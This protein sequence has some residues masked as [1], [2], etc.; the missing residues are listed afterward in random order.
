MVVESTHRGEHSR[1]AWP[2]IRWTLCVLCGLFSIPTS[3]AR[4]V[5]ATITGVTAG[6][7][8]YVTYSSNADGITAQLGRW[9]TPGDA[10]D[11]SKEPD[12]NSTLSIAI[13]VNDGGLVSFTY[14]ARSYDS[15][16]FD[17]LDVVLQT[18]TGDVPIIQNYGSQCNCGTLWW[19]DRKTKHQS[20]NKWKNQQVNFLIRVHQDGFGDQ[21]QA[22]IFNFGIRACPVPPLT[23]LTDPDSLPFENGYVDP[24]RLTESM[25]TGLACLRT[26]VTGAG[27]TY[28]DLTS[29]Y[30][31]TEY[32]QHLREVYDRHIEL[33][34][35]REQ[36]C[37]AIRN[38]VEIE[39]SHHQFAHR[40]ASATGPHTRG[41]AFDLPFTLPPGQ[42]IDSLAASC[43][44]RR[45]LTRDRVHF[46]HQ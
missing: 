18:P 34:D 43:Q 9:D 27:G 8:G 35:H 25:R 13:D 22:R 29:G 17:P 44:L 5:Q 45:P 46:V 32:Q 1:L 16:Y 41:E 30:R 42:N 19:G 10:Y 24:N 15:L 28:S 37:Q 36:A 20:L 4:G 31:P 6:G 33:Q 7:V 26:A 38:D 14:D 2:S 12:G 40:P 21:T 3:I 23:P 39:F 11:P